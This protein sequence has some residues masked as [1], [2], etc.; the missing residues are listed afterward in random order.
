MY[1]M[2]KDIWK[3]EFAKQIIIKEKDFIIG[4]DPLIG[5]KPQVNGFTMMITRVYYKCNGAISNKGYYE[6]YFTPSGI[7]SEFTKLTLLINNWK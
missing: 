6:S 1:K 5:Y 2:Y 4:Y 7:N 3:K